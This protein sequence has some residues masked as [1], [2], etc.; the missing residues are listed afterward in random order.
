M[1]T[2]PELKIEEIKACWHS[3]QIRVGNKIHIF[4]TLGEAQDFIDSQ[5]LD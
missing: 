2:N 3:I 4:Y 5:E 1:N